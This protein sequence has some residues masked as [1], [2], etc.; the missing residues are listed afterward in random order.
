MRGMILLLAALAVTAVLAVVAP[1]TSV[2]A[3][4]GP[5]PSARGKPVRVVAPAVR[6]PATSARVRIASGVG[7]PQG[8][9]PHSLIGVGFG[10]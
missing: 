8:V 4:E 7:V 6:K 9:R 1:T 2:S 5:E 3:A 10:F